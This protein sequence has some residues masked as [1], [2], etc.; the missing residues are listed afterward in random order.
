VT[1]IPEVVGT[2]GPVKGITTVVLD[3]TTGFGGVLGGGAGGL[4]GLVLMT[5]VEVPPG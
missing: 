4:V 5:P 1:V 3:V 2:T